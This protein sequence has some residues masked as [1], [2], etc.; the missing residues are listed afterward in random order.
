MKPIKR[1]EVP[2]VVQALRQVQSAK[3]LYKILLRLKVLFVILSLQ[4]I[5][6]SLD[7]DNRGCVRLARVHAIA[8]LQCHAHDLG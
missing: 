1:E 4:S 6:I 2:K 8:W 7:L 5:L 3:V